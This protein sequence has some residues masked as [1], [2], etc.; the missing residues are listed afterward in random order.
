M[1]KRK[2]VIDGVLKIIGIATIV[3]SILGAAL[4]FVELGWFPQ[5]GTFQLDPHGINAAASWV[6]TVMAPWPSLGLATRIVLGA[7]LPQANSMLARSRLN[8]SADIECGRLSKILVLPPYFLSSF[9]SGMWPTTGRLVTR[10]TSA[11]VR[12][13]SSSSWMTRSW[14]GYRTGRV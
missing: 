13:V 8:A 11:G 10:A 6:A 4:L 2:T 7:P 1:P 5:L 12:I 9:V 3:L 14:R